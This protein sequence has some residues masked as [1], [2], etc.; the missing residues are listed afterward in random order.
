MLSIILT[1]LL[2]DDDP[3]RF[4]AEFV[5][6]LDRAQWT[7]MWIELDGGSLWVLRRTIPVRF[8]R[9]LEVA[10]RDQ[11]PYLWLT[12]WQ[13]TNSATPIVRIGNQLTTRPA[14]IISL[15]VV[16]VNSEPYCH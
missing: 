12:G 6:G 5:D 3:A 1:G 14:A 11:M 4:V 10:Y 13:V 9:K 16:Q 8:C 7:E 2:L 15:S